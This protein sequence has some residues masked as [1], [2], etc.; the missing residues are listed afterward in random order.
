MTAI[1]GP[2]ES[3]PAAIEST[4]RI[5][6]GSA[7]ARIMILP[8]D[9]PLYPEPLRSIPGP[10]LFLFTRG[11]VPTD[12]NG[13]V[14]I[15]GTRSPDVEALDYTKLL[16]RTLAQISPRIIVSG[17]AVGIDSEAHRAA[18]NAGAP[19]VAVLGNGLD[20]IYPKS[21]MRLA[22][23]ILDQGG[24]L[25]SEVPI[26][27][28]V[29]RKALVARDRLQTGLSVATLLIQSSLLGGSMHAARFALM[30]ERALFAMTPPRK[31]PR[32]LGNTFLLGGDFDERANAKALAR[33]RKYRIRGP[34]AV[35][36][37]PDPSSLDISRQLTANSMVRQRNSGVTPPK[38]DTK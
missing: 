2:N 21:N 3:Y 1:A 10:P 36:L 16:V 17:L 19:T 30:Q 32:W 31:D 26:G 35:P 18:L 11:Q 29:R 25:V 27:T 12:W 34:L 37:G 6:E 7:K 38:L 5:V 20:T 9:D 13:A 8:F 15:I 33:F 4:T 23:L 24:C 14:A 22:E 28:G